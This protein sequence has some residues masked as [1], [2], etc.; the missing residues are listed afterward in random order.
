MVRQISAFVVAL[1]FIVSAGAGFAQAQDQTQAPLRV[2]GV[3][4]APTK[5]KN[6]EP[7][8]PAAAQEQGIEGVVILELLINETGAVEEVKVLRSVP[9]LDESAIEAV[10][11]WVYNI[12]VAFSLKSAAA[13]AVAPAPDTAA[14]AAS[15]TGP[16]PRGAVDNPVSSAMYKSAVRVGGVIRAPTKLVN[17]APLVSPA[18]LQQGQGVVILELLIAPEGHVQEIKVLRGIPHLN[19]AAIDAVQQWVYAPTL[20][21]GVPTAVIYNITVSFSAQP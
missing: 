1:A 21:N 5:I 17:V 16:P 13:S 19:Q 12:T 11:Q 14:T 20:L 8:Y 6:V 10:L 4:K 3:I 2:G 18:L 9:G 15:V 7:V